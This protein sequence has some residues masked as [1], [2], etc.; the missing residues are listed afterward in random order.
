MEDTA[1]INK[2]EDIL[3]QKIYVRS[4][5]RIRDVITTNVPTDILENVNGTEELEDV[6]EMKNVTISM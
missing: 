2:S 4:S 5:S 1:N 6:R 3:I